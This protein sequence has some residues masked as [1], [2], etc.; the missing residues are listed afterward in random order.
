MHTLQRSYTISR[1]VIDLKGM[2]DLAAKIA[3]SVVGQ[4]GT[5]R[6]QDEVELARSHDLIPT[7]EFWCL[8]R[9]VGS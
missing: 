1:G 4:Q 9:Y 6:V 2:G 7:R 8:N 3:A 5:K